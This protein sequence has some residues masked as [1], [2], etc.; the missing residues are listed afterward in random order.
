MTKAEIVD[1]VSNEDYMY[2][3]IKRLIL[4]SMALVLCSCASMTTD[5]VLHGVELGTAPVASKLA[6]QT[7]AG[8][9]ITEI[10]TDIYRSNKSPDKEQPVLDSWEKE[11]DNNPTPEKLT[12]IIVHA[13]AEAKDK[14]WEMFQGSDKTENS[15]YAYLVAYS[16]PPYQEKAWNYLLKHDLQEADMKYVASTA[17]PP[18]NEKAKEMLKTLQPK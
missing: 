18:Y 8:A 13:S 16:A 5:N 17:P 4:L 15:Q 7:W 1:L 9:M 2:R 10:A 6:S 14:A 12:Y 3:N 11:L